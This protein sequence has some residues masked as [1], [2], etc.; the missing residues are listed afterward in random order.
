MNLSGADVE[1]RCRGR[2]GRCQE[3]RR[4]R[5]EDGLH[6]GQVDVRPVMVALLVA[7]LA[8]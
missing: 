7:A 6:L 4:E 5:C 8:D 2:E 3:E 1:A